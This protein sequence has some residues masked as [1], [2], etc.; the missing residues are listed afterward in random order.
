MPDDINQPREY[1]VVLGGQNLPPIDGVVLGGI[2][3]VK[4]RLDSV[5]SQEV[6][7]AALSDALKY[8]EEG[9]A[10]L[11]QIVLTETGNLQWLAYDL[12]FNSATENQ[13]QNL[14]QYIP[15]QSAVGVDYRSLRNL[16]AS[17]EWLQANLETGEKIQ[18]AV[19]K[20]SQTY[21]DFRDL[22]NLSQTDLRT[23]DQLWVRFSNNHFGFSVQKRILLE[24]GCHFCERGD[25]NTHFYN[26]KVRDV[27]H[28]IYITYKKLGWLSLTLDKSKFTFE[29]A[30]IGSLPTIT[31][32]DIIGGWN[33]EIT[34]MYRS[35]L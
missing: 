18:E 25:Y 31:G 16:L 8:G 9:Q 26:P 12:L 1:D 7:I 35:D 10:L 3:G 2:E 32:K 27:R 28:S 14:L 17:G 11:Q 30:P 5:H 34:L 21:F 22:V 6:R 33:Y 19:G 29:K 23:I 15:L 13:K 24:E 4:L 20:K